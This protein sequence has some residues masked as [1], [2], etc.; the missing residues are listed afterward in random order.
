LQLN[1][2]DFLAGFEACTLSEFHHRDHLRVTWLLVRRDGH[3]GAKASI[4]AG[5][6]RFA[7]SHGRADKYHQTMT[8][9]WVDAVAHL[10]AQGKAYDSFDQFLTQW[11]QVLDTTLPF[12]HWTREAIMDGVAR[13]RWVPPDLLPLPWTSRHGP[14]L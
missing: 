5:I 12:R 14:Y 3:A 2:A 9:F 8:E 13:S 6:K 11:P 7:R 4:E 1:D 10:I